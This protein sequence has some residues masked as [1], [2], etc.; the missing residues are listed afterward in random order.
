MVKIEKM[1]QEDFWQCFSCLKSKEETDMY[2]IEIGKN[3]NQQ[4]SV[5][6]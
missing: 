6:R 3:L 4:S 1:N 2:E 5:T